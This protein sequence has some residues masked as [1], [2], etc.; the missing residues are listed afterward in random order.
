[1]L[2]VWE[3]STS[4]GEY[5]WRPGRTHDRDILITVENADGT[6]VKA[7]GP[8]WGTP[9]CRAFWK[10]LATAMKAALRKRGLE[11]SMHFGLLGDHRATQQAMD[12]ITKGAPGTKWAVHSHDFASKWMGY[13]V[14]LC[15][16]FWGCCCKP[17]DPALRRGYGWQNKFWLMYNPRD[18]MT[19]ETQLARY[20]TVTESWLGASQ[21][22]ARFTHSFTKEV[23]TSDRTRVRGIGRQ[24]IDFWKVLPGR[25]RR[26]RSKWSHTLA[27]R[28]PE[29][30]WGHLNFARGVP[31]LTG[32]GADGAA[33]TVRYEG[34]RENVQECEARIF[35][36][37]A[38][39]DEQLKA[40]LG[41]ALA[42]RAQAV[43]DERTRTALYLQYTCFN[44]KVRSWPS[45]VTG[46][47]HRTEQLFATTVAV[48]EALTRPA[49]PPA[50]GRRP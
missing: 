36:E 22:Y 10:T 48:A 6:L 33:P 9:E 38:L 24:G 49:P 27:G 17:T 21:H 41:P 29:S 28:Y 18:S 15:A 43:L 45:F 2:Y 8:A 32:P 20:R 23:I 40:R 5:G 44:Y 50:D 19:A 35:I 7:T 3:P 4:G 46:W 13:E 26:G 34:L 12:D 31:Y 25:S 16:A 42:R 11:T 14:G 39:V 37:K 47:R 1:V 30:E